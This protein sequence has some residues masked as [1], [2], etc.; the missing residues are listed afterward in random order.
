M[1]RW[2]QYGGFAAGIVLIVFGVVA[3][4]MPAHYTA[5]AKWLH[6]LV[7]VLILAPIVYAVLGGFKDNGQLAAN[8]VALIPDPWVLTNYTDVLFG[9]NA[10]VFWRELL[11]SLIVAAV[12]V[13]VTVGCASAAAF[14]RSAISCFETISLPG[15]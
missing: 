7:A 11:N 4:A 1:R 2:L 14:T 5:T 10:L 9:K 6:W 3:I 12:A 13:G 15:R 8:P